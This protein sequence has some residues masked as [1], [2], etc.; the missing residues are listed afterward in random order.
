[1]QVY[2]SWKK[3]AISSG[4][5]IPPAPSDRPGDWVDVIGTFRCPPVSAVLF[6]I[7]V[8]GRSAHP[9]RQEVVASQETAEATD[10][11]YIPS[12]GTRDLTWGLGLLREIVPGRKSRVASPHDILIFLRSVERRWPP[13]LRFH[14]IAECPDRRMRD[15]LRRWLARRPAYTFHI[16]ASSGAWSAAVDR[17]LRGWDPRQLAL[18]SFRAVEWFTRALIRYASR[19][20]APSFAFTWTFHE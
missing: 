9:P 4:L 2:R 3:H 8:T 18:T 1:M 10:L 5:P 7:D 20:E 19:P 12:R 6:G 16:V 15:H 11:L 14:L 17:F 13:D